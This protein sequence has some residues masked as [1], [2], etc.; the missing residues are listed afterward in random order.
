MVSVKGSG[1]YS[2]NVVDRGWQ[3]YWVTFGANLG[4]EYPRP[5][6]MPTATC[7]TLALILD[8]SHCRPKLSI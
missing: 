4:T 5:D 8:Q 2:G 1:L 6:P 3:L 7:H